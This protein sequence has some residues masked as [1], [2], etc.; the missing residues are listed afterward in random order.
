MAHRWAGLTVREILRH[1]K[2]S[3]K[4]A[5]LPAGSPS[6]LEFEPM[7]WEEIEEGARMNQPGYK[8][9]RKLLADRRFDR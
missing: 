2:G 6:W 7:R 8:M 1:K 3:I 9:V 4:D 5:P